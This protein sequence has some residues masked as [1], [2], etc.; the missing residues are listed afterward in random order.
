[1]VIPSS[2]AGETGFPVTRSGTVPPQR[3]VNDALAVSGRSEQFRKAWAAEHAGVN[4]SF[5]RSEGGGATYRL[6]A[7]FRDVSGDI[8]VTQRRSFTGVV[9]IVRQKAGAVILWGLWLLAAAL[10]LL[11]IWGGLRVYLWLTGAA[12]PAGFGTKYALAAGLG[13][14][15]TPWFMLRFAGRPDDSAVKDDESGALGVLSASTYDCLA[16]LIVWALLVCAGWA[17]M[18]AIT[19]AALVLRF[20]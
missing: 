3:L 19:R 14:I 18:G 7:A 8:R 16:R 6:T 9:T 17:I 5:V 1:M 4:I 20:D 2:R 11:G 10:Y 13:P 12:R 15:L